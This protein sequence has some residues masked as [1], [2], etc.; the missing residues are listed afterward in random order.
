MAPL[1]VLVPITLR[2]YS[3]YSEPKIF[4]FMVELKCFNAFANF[5]MVRGFDALFTKHPLLICTLLLVKHQIP[6][7]LNYFFF[8]YLQ[9]VIYDFM[10]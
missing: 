6:H 1:N 9:E 3:L 5:N 2:I 8:Y 4:E 10:L 7:R